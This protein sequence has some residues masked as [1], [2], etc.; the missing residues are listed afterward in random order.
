MNEL[1][2]T[3]PEENTQIAFY[4]KHSAI[5]GRGGFKNGV[6]E[7][8]TT[9]RLKSQDQKTLSDGIIEVRVINYQTLSLNY[10]NLAG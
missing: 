7:I 3:L 9:G 8:T 4:L 6:F 1:D 2:N 5:L 10:P